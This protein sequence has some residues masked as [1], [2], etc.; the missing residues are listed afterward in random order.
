MFEDP[1]TT[2]PYAGAVTWDRAGAL[3]V[4]VLF[5]PYVLLV[6][7][8]L[9]GMVELIDQCAAES[10]GTGIDARL[11][12]PV[13]RVRDSRDE[14][15]PDAEVLADIRAR[16]AWALSVLPDRGGVVELATAQEQWWFG[17]ALL[18]VSTAILALLGEWLRGKD[19]GGLPC[20]DD[21]TWEVWHRQMNWLNAQFVD[22]LRP[23]A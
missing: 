13:R 20:P 11:A 7:A 23:A 10:D 12:L 8:H 6:R 4:A 19:V 2:D 17:H 1:A 14:S 5:P 18:D 22:P 16:Q 9:Q 21:E 3:R 15:R